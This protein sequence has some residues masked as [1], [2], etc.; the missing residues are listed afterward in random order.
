MPEETFKYSFTAAGA[1]GTGLSVYNSGFQKCTAGHMWGPGLRD[2]FLIHH[3]VAGRG[4]YSVNGQTFSV[5]AGHT[6]LV[7]PSTI[8]SYQADAVAPWEYYWVGFNGSNAPLL[9]AQT[10][11]SP[12]HPV[13][14][15][16]FGPALRESLL[17]IYEARG[18]APWQQAEM[19]GRLYLALSLFIRSAEKAPAL[20]P[21]KLYVAQ[22][23]QYIAR[24]YSRPIDVSLLAR[25][26]GVSRSNLF[27]AFMKH[28][29]MPPN[30]YLTTFR[31]D[32]ACEHLRA[33]GMSVAQVASSV[34]YDDPMYFSRV[35]KRTKGVSPREFLKKARESEGSTA[36]SDRG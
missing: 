29:H 31:I 10:D 2:H 13:I 25:S 18:S 26:I 33:G 12:E 14:T 11:F 4:V 34:G 5:E 28:L 21:G 17:G 19:T 15:T 3:V 30:Q 6:F 16:D 22:A 32:L 24:N 20:S 27:R 7:Y 9:M 35:F 36:Q 23:V 8:V 1:D